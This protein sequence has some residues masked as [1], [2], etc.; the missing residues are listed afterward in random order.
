MQSLVSE[1]ELILCLRVCTKAAESEYVLVLV[2]AIV[3]ACISE[4]FAFNE[5][6]AHHPLT[7]IGL[8][9]DLL[10]NERMERSGWWFVLIWHLGG[11]CFMCRF[12]FGFILALLAG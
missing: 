10:Y 1:D 6:S 9:P 5:S 2:L 11:K 4:S 8:W 7:L 12:G 3:D